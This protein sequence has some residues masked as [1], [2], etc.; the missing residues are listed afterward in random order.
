MT[1]IFLVFQ[2]EAELILTVL[3]VPAEE[4]NSAEKTS[5]LV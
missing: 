1:E 5:L 4:G 3:L 2:D